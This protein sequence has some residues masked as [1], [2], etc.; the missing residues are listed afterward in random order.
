MKREYLFSL[1]QEQIAA[2]TRHLLSTHAPKLSVRSISGNLIAGALKKSV[3]QLAELEADIDPNGCVSIRAE[4][5]PTGYWW[6]LRD[7]HALAALHCASAVLSGRSKSQIEL[8]VFYSNAADEVAR[9]II[10]SVLAGE[11]TSMIQAPS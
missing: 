11:T 5:I 1:Q 8:K 3:E 10:R 6:L 2:A 4:E 9:E 7:C